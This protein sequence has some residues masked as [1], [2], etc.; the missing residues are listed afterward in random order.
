MGLFLCVEEN[1]RVL[2][3]R[4]EGELSDEVLLYRYGIV[5]G[6]MKAKGSHS[7]IFDLSDVSSF[8]VTSNCIRN[9]Q[10]ILP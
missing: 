1:R 5:R 9:L 2:Y 3:V 4:F 7:R 6:W 10:P 8:P